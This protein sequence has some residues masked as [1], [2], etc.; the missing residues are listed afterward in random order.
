MRK[1]KHEWRS[2][3]LPALIMVGPI[4]LV[5]MFLVIVPLIYVI[6]M[7][8][9]STDSH[10]NVVFSFTIKNYAQ[11]FD[12]SYVHIYLQSLAIAFLTTVICV[13]IAQQAVDVTAHQVSK[14]VV[15][16]VKPFSHWSSP[17]FSYVP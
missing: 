7:S 6:V 14:L 17:W 12:P 13:L 10:F 3:S 2:N 5:M 1:S 8:F 11:L 4:V 15:V 9:C 16:Y